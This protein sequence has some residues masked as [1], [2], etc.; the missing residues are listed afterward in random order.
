[1][2]L[3]NPTPYI[4]RIVSRTSPLTFQWLVS[5]SF[6]L[7][8]TVDCRPCSL[9]GLRISTSKFSVGKGTLVVHQPPPPTTLRSRSSP[10]TPRGDF[11][12]YVPLVH[13][14]FSVLPHVESLCFP[15][16]K[17]FWQDTT[18][19]DTL[20]FWYTPSPNQSFLVLRLQF[21]TVLPTSSSTRCETDKRSR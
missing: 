15:Q 6:L 19:Y 8:W 13:S 21:P 17:L 3:L 16:S 14:S 20:N 11:C 4:L 7:S 9:F 1:M 18:V 10:Q 2:C 5:L 12:Q